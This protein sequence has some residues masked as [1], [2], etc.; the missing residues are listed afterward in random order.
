MSYKITNYTKNKA[1][2]LGVEVKPSHNKGKK[3][4]V[5]NNVETLNFV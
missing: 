1:K 2:E 4:D 3:I 5:L